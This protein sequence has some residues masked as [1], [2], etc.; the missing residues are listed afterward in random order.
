MDLKQH[1]QGE[2]ERIGNRRAATCCLGVFRGEAPILSGGN[3]RSSWISP[4]RTG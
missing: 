4:R 3:V 2:R 1:Y